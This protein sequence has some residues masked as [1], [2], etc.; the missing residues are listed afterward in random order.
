[1]AGFADNQTALVRDDDGFEI[2]VLIRECVV[3]ETDD[4]NI[5]RP[6][7]QAPIPNVAPEGP[8]PADNRFRTQ[9]PDTY[10]HSFDDDEDDKPITFRPRPLE[11]RGA[12]VLNIFLGY[13]P[14]DTKNLQTT[15]FEAYLINDSNYY[16][17][18]ALFTHDG[19]TCALRHEGIVE[20][21]TKNFLEEFTISLTPFQR[22]FPK[23][24]SGTLAPAPAHSENGGF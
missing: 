8:R 21:N 5:A 17:H 10:T 19:A 23:P 6:Q 16:I 2:P 24:R 7:K 1:M 20:P 3:I 12:D 11:R 18:Y 4:Y 9:Q 14:M 22:L 13:V 15:A